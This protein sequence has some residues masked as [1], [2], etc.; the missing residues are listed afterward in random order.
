[1]FCGIV[2]GLFLLSVGKGLPRG[3]ELAALEGGA[4][5][6]GGRSLAVRMQWQRVHPEH[7]AC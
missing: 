4:A 2:D 6:G 5:V 7:A 3:L 1:M